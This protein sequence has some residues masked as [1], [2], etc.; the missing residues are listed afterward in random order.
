MTEYRKTQFFDGDKAK[1]T[2]DLSGK[3]HDPKRELTCYCEPDHCLCYDKHLKIDF[4]LKLN[5][6]VI[7]HREISF[8]QKSFKDKASHT[9][10]FLPEYSTCTT[11]L[12]YLS[13]K[14]RNDS[15][16]LGQL[17]EFVVASLCSA[18]DHAYNREYIRRRSE[19]RGFLK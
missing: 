12:V 6:K 18:T 9:I 14:I 10:T 11:D 15:F 1:I 17:E 2:F 13:S 4:S 7:I 5:G 19:V 16:K 3:V 8:S